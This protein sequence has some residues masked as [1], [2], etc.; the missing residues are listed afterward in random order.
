M[1]E[2]ASYFKSQSISAISRICA[3]VVTYNRK[4]LLADNINSLLRQTRAP[5]SI[6]VVDNA[7]T[8]GTD[9][10]VTLLCENNP[11][12]HYIRLPT[13]GGGAA[14]FHEGIKSAYTQGFDWLWLMDD[15]G[16]PDDDCL[17]QLLKHI[18]KYD[19]LGPLI[20]S[21]SRSHSLFRC[22]SIITDDLNILKQSEILYPVHPFNGILIN[23]CVIEKIGYPERRLFIWGDEQDYR[24][25]WIEAG[26]REASF[27]SAIYFHPFNR[28]KLKSYGFGLKVPEIPSRRKYLF[29]RN[30]AWID[31]RH[32]NLFYSA[33]SIFRWF[34]SIALF[35]KNKIHSLKG[36]LD[37]LRGDLSNPRI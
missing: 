32:R 7:S 26:F 8:D 3:V 20:C 14:G 21:G 18:D 23:H 16:K 27:S 33:L 11:Q 35:D 9:E 36:L 34:L 10:F 4:Q 17:E 25:R 13:N 6:M 29:Y 24:L 31:L 28:L 15:D 2:E 30:Q 37:G 12:L 5:D 22:G 1:A 19:V